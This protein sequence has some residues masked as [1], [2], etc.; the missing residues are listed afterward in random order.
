[1]VKIYDFHNDSIDLDLKEEPMSKETP[2]VP[3][4]PEEPGAERFE[5]R[6]YSQV[7]KLTLSG[8]DIRVGIDNDTRELSEPSVFLHIDEGYEAVFMTANEAR[9]PIAALTCAINQSEGDM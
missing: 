5:K 4:P 7:A 3:T 6:P 1:M 9:L 2:V 8:S